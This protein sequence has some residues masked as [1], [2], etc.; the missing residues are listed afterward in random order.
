MTVLTKGCTK[1]HQTPFPVLKSHF[2]QTVAF[3]NDA[4]HPFKSPIHTDDNQLKQCLPP[5]VEVT[6]CQCKAH[7][8]NLHIWANAQCI[9]SNM[10]RI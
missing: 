6:R 3:P 2:Y 5:L 10:P 9:W 1:I 8:I 4:P 7:L